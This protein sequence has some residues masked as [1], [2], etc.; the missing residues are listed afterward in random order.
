MTPQT[1]ETALR[2][3]EKHA[4][5]FKEYGEDFSWIPAAAR[6]AVELDD[7]IVA[8]A[9]AGI[10]PF[11]EYRAEIYLHIQN[12]FKCCK[13]WIGFEVISFYD[14]YIPSNGI[15]ES[16]AKIAQALGL[17]IYKYTEKIPSTENFKCPYIATARES[18]LTKK[19]LKSSQISIYSKVP[20]KYKRVEFTF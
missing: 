1:S 19:N 15:W 16:A 11:N 6:D 5:L 12:I 20:N 4:D 18:D 9:N 14:N 2:W 8:L 17:V 10:S 13:G 3:I 7:V